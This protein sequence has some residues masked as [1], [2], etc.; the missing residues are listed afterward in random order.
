MYELIP[1]AYF[2]KFNLIISKVNDRVEK[3]LDDPSEENIHDLRTAIR[4]LGSA[5]S[6][7]PK[8]SKKKKT[9]KFVL[10]CKKFFR[11]SSQIRD[12][13]IIRQRLSEYKT[14]QINVV[15]KKIDGK[16]QKALKIAQK[17]A[18]IVIEHTIN[19]IDN[20]VIIPEKLEKKFKKTT[21]EQLSGIEKA[22]PIVTS[23]E[24]KVKELHE[25]RKNCKK[26]RYLLE[27][28]NHDESASFI[29]KLKEMQDLLGLIRDIDITI[30]LL[31]KY[32][33]KTKSLEPIIKLEQQKR[34][35]LYV[36]FVEMQRTKIL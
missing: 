11:S 18:E 4:R 35:Q 24:K 28:T 23:N 2:E 8:S 32:Y 13:D 1:Q 5:W 33:K 36:K 10:S 9:E 16:K 3:I 20:D 21:F 15:L 31:K 22:I 17:K 7:V 30:D 29:K 6:I 34:N 26:L 25:L 12:I 14:E 27:L 19:K